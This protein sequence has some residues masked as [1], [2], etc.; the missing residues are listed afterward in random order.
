MIHRSL[1]AMASAVALSAF[2]MPNASYAQVAPAAPSDLVTLVSDATLCPSGQANHLGLRVLSDALGGTIFDPG[3]VCVVITSWEWGPIF[4][5]EA[6]HWESAELALETPRG[7]RATVGTAGNS[8]PGAQA[9]SLNNQFTG[10]NASIVGMIAVKPG[11]LICAST[12][13]DV[14]GFA[15]VHGF[16]TLDK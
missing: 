7:G 16:L 8:S 1:V 15:I 4:T 11:V 10:H 6:N 3:R 14:R 5:R 9:N 2:S 13:S 12:S